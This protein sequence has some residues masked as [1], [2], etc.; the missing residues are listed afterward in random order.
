MATIQKKQR[1]S[2]FTPFEVH[3]RRHEQFPIDTIVKAN[4]DK[5]AKMMVQQALKKS[6]QKKDLILRLV[7]L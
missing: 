5:N 6:I 4:L 7:T 2:K 3:R 1:S